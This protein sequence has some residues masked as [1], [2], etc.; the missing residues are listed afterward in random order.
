MMG[1]MMGPYGRHWYGLGEQ[2]TAIDIRSSI[3][4][5]TWPS[6][7]G[8]LQEAWSVLSRRDELEPVEHRRPVPKALVEC[9]CVCVKPCT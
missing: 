8:H 5:K 9:V 7:R 2:C 1:S 3:H 4:T 6:T